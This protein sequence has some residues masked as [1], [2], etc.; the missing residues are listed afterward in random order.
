M[1][2]QAE[3]N[4]IAWEYRAYEAR[5]S[6]DTI[7]EQAR[8][9][10]KNPKARLRYHARYFENIAGKRIAN[11]CG[12][13]GR[14]TV[15]F[16]VL[17]A[18]ATLFDISEPQIK[19][20]L[21]LAEAVG[22]KLEYVLGDFIETDINKY[23]NMF[24]FLYLEGGIIHYFSNIDEFTKMLYAISK[25][26]GRL[27]LCDM[28]PY[29]KLDNLFV[30]E[31]DYFDSRLHDNDAPLRTVFPEEEQE[32]F[33]KISV[34]YYTISEIINSVIASGFMIKEFIEHPHYKDPAR[35]MEFTIIADKI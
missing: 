11:V 35:P 1:R 27:I 12:S 14:R 7:Q 13:D 20:A 32:A 9:I 5:T 25:S 4:K 16:A 15:P 24:D 18:E 31:G 3:Q 6:G 33:P 28:H 19:Y 8:K 10:L 34:R 23:G 21:E 30:T 29:R 22:V 17:G 2:E 26:N